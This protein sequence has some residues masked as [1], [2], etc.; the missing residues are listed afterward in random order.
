M[1][2]NLSE[3]TDSHMIIPGYD[4]E[5]LQQFFKLMYTWV[6]PNDSKITDLYT[7]ADK[8]DVRILK[9]KCEEIILR[10]VN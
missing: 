2:T 8:Y 4:A 6:L 7:L 5:T 9:D 1:S 3:Q 10:D